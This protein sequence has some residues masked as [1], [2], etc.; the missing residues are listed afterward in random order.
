MMARLCLFSVLVSSLL[1]WTAGPVSAQSRL[2]LVV[3]HNLGT[4]GTDPL[5]YAEDDARRVFDVLMDLGE[6]DDGEL[7]LSPSLSE[8][9]AALVR[10]TAL[11]E[12]HASQGQPPLVL[13][14]FAGH[15]DEESLYLAN[16]RLQREHLV[17]RLEALSAS[18]RILVLDSCQTPVVGQ[19]RGVNAE[20][21]F[22][23]GVVQPPTIEGTVIIS[24]TQGGAPA[25]ESEA[26]GGAIFTHYLVSA[27]RGAGDVDG[28]GRV[29]LLEGYD[30][31]YRSTVMRSA[32]AGSVLQRPEY[33][34]DLM[35][36]G[37][38]VLSTLDWG[39]A[40]LRILP[41]EEKRV[42]IFQQRTGAIVAE[43]ITS[44]ERS[45]DIA[46]PSGILLVQRRGDDGILLAE[47]YV[48][49][50]ETVSLDDVDFEEQPYELVTLRGG[51]YDLHPHRTQISYAFQT[52][53]FPSTWVFRHGPLL[54]YA[55]RWKGWSAGIGV[56][57]SFAD[58]ESSRYDE[59]EWALEAG[60]TI[61]WVQPLGFTDLEIWG[62]PTLQWVHQERER[63]DAERLNSAGIAVQIE[64]NQ[65][66]G[67]GA[68][69]GIGWRVPLND[70]WDL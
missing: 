32:G 47:V 36:S 35:G 65:A 20:P 55:Y 22:D 51:S 54:R 18:L 24:S 61:G 43:V 67:V 6:F 21:A 53:H 49:R 17:A 44:T 14:Y 42:V 5:R 27:L 25:L 70:I 63:L 2:A 31:A 40:T 10:L 13:F 38:V 11:A 69:F 16:L 26:L 39:E 58:F 30:F 19:A 59:N 52:A 12:Q 62:G 56:G 50:G 57:A 3:G 46:V 66:L 33:E 4:S 7:L 9:D 15:G 28:D 68:E 23:V 34:L 8:V 41:D 37:E 60:A 48:G 29:S 1:L 45:Y 64:D